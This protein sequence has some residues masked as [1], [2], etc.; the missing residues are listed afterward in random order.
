MQSSRSPYYGRGMRSTV[1]LL[2]HPLVPSVPDDL[3]PLSA[4]GVQGHVQV[5][6]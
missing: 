3:V 1:C 2:L 5:K 6:G 4:C